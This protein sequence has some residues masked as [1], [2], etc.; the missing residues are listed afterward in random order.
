MLLAHSLWRPSLLF[1]ATLDSVSLSQAFLQSFLSRS[2][3]HRLKLLHVGPCGLLLQFTSILLGW[4][5]PNYVY[6]ENMVGLW[7]YCMSAQYDMTQLLRALWALLTL[8]CFLN[9]K[10]FFLQ[11]YVYKDFQ[12]L[13][14]TKIPW[15]WGWHHA[16]LYIIIKDKF[17]TL[18]YSEQSEIKRK[19]TREEF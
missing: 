5:N 8:F 2:K 11:V 4:G 17:Q 7:I 9:T 16:E 15:S 3:T 14:R 1:Q 6:I 19:E 12:I 18:R 13:T 10:L